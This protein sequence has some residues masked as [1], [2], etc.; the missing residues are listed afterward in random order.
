[1]TKIEQIAADILATIRVNTHS[2][3]VATLVAQWESNIAWLGYKVGGKRWQAELMSAAKAGWIASTQ[4]TCIAIPPSEET[5]A[6]G[7]F[8]G[9]E[10][11]PVPEMYKDAEQRFAEK[12]GA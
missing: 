6:W 5:L 10:I 4:I 11:I 9:G 3:T 8:L 1:M 2:H 12:F 7:G